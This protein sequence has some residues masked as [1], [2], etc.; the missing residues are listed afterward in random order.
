MEKDYLLLKVHYPEH[1]NEIGALRIKAW[2]D[3]EGT[4]PDFFSKSIW[5]DELDAIAHHWIITYRGTIVASAR[6]TLHFHYDNV[7][8][9]ELL[10]DKL[11]NCGALPIA[12]INRLVVHPEH[13]GNGLAKMLDQERINF[14][15][16]YGVKTILVQP[17]DNRID[18]LKKLGYQ[19][20][21]KIKSPYEI[22]ARNLY[23]M[24]KRLDQDI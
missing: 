4:D 5:L 11:E 2:R 8:Y 23:L 15:K 22:R 10:D 17:L 13:R 7:P 6:L 24:V 3:E 1:I 19:L 18:P 20:V 16:A 9:R 12:S 14:A 21:G